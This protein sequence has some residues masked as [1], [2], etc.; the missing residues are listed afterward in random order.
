LTSGRAGDTASPEGDGALRALLH[1]TTLALDRYWAAAAHREGVG[2]TELR[3]LVHLVR[4][5]ELT[6]GQLAARLG[7]TSG[8][9]TGL[10]RR[11]ERE[12]GLTRVTD[13]RDARRALLRPTPAAVERVA[14]LERALLAALDAVAGRRSVREHA[15]VVGFL[16]GVVEATE[17]VT[18]A[19]RDCLDQ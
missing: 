2:E 14:A 8:G 5:G 9:L 11:V 7:L 15:V 1:R 4:A 16:D 12:G 17:S 10:I 3:L 18:S 6:P 13:P 19:R